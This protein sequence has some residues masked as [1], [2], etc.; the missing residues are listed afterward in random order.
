MINPRSASPNIDKGVLIL[1]TTV[2]CYKNILKPVYN[3]S[4]NC[5]RIYAT[6]EN[7][8]ELISCTVKCAVNVSNDVTH[9]YIFSDFLP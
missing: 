7:K 2:V 8:Q 4:R 9:N 5:E 3:P 1:P 6:I